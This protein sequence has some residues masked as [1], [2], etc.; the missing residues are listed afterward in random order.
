M[1][2]KKTTILKKMISDNG[3]IIAPG[4]Y[5]CLSAKLIEKAG[6]RLIITTG[7]GI[8]ASILGVPDMGL[9]TM[10]EILTSTKN[11]VN[12][13]T[14][15]VL[16]DCDNGYGGIHN[17]SRTVKEF[18]AAGVAGLWIEDQIF[19]KR[20]GHFSGKKIIS[21]EEM[22]AKIK[23][24]MATRIDSDMM[25]MVR[26]DARADFGIDEAVNRA[27]AYIEAGADSIFIEAPQTLDELKYIGSA[28]DK[29]LMVNLVEGGKT[30]LL[31]ETELEDMGFKIITYSGSLQKIS[32]KAMT[33]FL[34]NLSGTGDVHKFLDDMF[35]LN[36]RSE[37]LDLNKLYD[38]EE[39]FSF[40]ETT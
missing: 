5:D 15:P 6:Y 21:K 3:V 34:E 14:L 22:C 33:N 16:A 26:T 40:P 20:C 38:L 19:P 29:P 8:C 9:A 11:I 13:T 17:V 35:S 28:I 36:E 10:T 7:A 24:A 12:S 39:R 4:A 25:I 2:M 1:K 32:L 27:K 18:E 37:I 23:V 30:P 31:S